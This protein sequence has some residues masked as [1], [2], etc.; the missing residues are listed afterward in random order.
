[1][2]TILVAFA[3]AFVVST[4]LTPQVR[5]FAIRR[6]LFDA[7]SARKVHARPI[8]RLGGVAIVIGALVPLSG[9]LI[10]R[11]GA[12]HT[13][14]ASGIQVAGFFA[15]GLAIAA[16]GLIDDLRG[17][18]AR[19]KFT[20]Q[21][22][23]AAAMYFLG[24]Q[25][26][27]VANPFG[28]SFSLGYLAL[29]FTMFWIVG[30]INAMN[31]IDGLDGLA[32]GVAFFAVLMNF[33]VSLSRG[34]ILMG[35]LMAALAGA[36]LGFL[37]FNFNPASIFMG[38]TGSMFLGFIL[39]TGSLV[40]SQKGAAAVSML[41]PILALGLPI[42]DTLLAMIRRYTLGRPVFSA[43][44]EHIHHRL[45]RLGYT[46][47]R[48]VL[49]MY[50]ICV[51]FTLAALGITFANQ[52]QAALILTAVAGVVF[53]IVRRLGYVDFS[54]ARAAMATRKKNLALRATVIDIGEALQHAAQPEAIWA[55]VRDISEP[56]NLAS[57]SLQL[58]GVATDPS[59]N[60]FEAI[61]ETGPGSPIEVVLP[62]ELEG[63][64]HGELRARWN[65][66]RIEVGRDDEL[67]LE[68]LVDHV[69]RALV[70]NAATP[71]RK[72]LRLVG[73]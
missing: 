25:I 10:Y 30:V 44:R 66:G 1:V 47:R 4:V 9:L 65:D 43:D 39:A 59:H 21:F 55:C 12:T 16:L 41:V 52:R 72:P 36:I 8:P 15:G 13:F 53:F 34:D 31:L 17:L 68:L 14:E 33:V 48:A 70:R 57:L 49:S 29:P 42:M 69:K 46:H 27:G 38:D 22:L 40:T 19:H 73:R 56:L 18:R 50:A 20:V 64:R 58:G 51:V 6:G 28:A 32:G 71:S 23:V 2:I 37:I 60:R 45:L 61:R 54:Q 5:D 26:H 63:E 11:S 35:L 3:M 24:F 67:A 62:V 7:H